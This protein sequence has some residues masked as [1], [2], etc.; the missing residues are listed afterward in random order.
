MNNRIS[1]LFSS[2]FILFHSYNFEN[3]KKVNN[4]TVNSKKTVNYKI[5]NNTIT[6]DDNNFEEAIE[7]NDNI[8]IILYTFQ[9][10]YSKILL[11]LFEK[12]AL[13]Y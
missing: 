3:A 5:I 2:L 13:S 1:I 9:C 4:Q 12:A 7:K 8:I 11:P 10:K 6:L